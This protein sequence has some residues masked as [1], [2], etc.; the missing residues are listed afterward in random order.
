MPGI[1]VGAGDSV[2][3]FVD[4]VFGCEPGLSWASTGTVL[5]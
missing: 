1:V 5:P 3:S 4:V 2:R